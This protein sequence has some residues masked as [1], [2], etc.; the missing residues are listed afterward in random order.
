MKF[1][2][3]SLAVLGAIALAGCNSSSSDSNDNIVEPIEGLKVAFMPD[4]HFHDVYGVFE[5]GS[6]DGLPNSESGLN[7]TIRTMQSQMES[8]RLFN[9]NYF[10]MIAALDDV[11]ARGIKYVALP[12]DFSDDGQPVHM[13]GLVRI[14]DQYR[15]KHG[16]EFFAAPG[17]HDPVRPFTI[18][19]GKG[20]FLG[21]DGKQQRIYSRDGADECVGYDGDW[22][23]IDAGY[24]LPTI[25]T[26]EIQE[27]GYFE[28]MDILGHHGFFPQSNYVYFETP[29]SSEEARNNY[30]LELAQKEAAFERRQY[31]ICHEGTGGEYKKD[32]YTACSYIPD[33]TYL[34][35]P[36]EGLWLM[37][38]DANVY[39]PVAGGDDN[40]TNG[41]N[42]DGSSNAGYNKMLTHKEHVIDWIEAT[43]KAAKEQNKV[44]FSFSH[45]PM[46]D[47]Y[48]GASEEIEDIFGEGNF[49]LKRVPEDDTSKALAATGLSIHVGG[50]MHFND[51]GVKQYEIDGE[52]YTLF[53]IQAP[54]LAGYIPAYKILEIK[55]DHQ[56]EVETAV[57]KNVP[58][59]NELFEHY[60]IEQ[61]HLESIGKDDR[62][63][64]E[65][66][67]AETYYD[68]TDWHIRELTRLRFLPREWPEDVKRML[69][70]MDGDQMLILSQLQ[71]D[72]TVCQ[73][74][75]ALSEVSDVE[76]CVSGFEDQDTLEQFMLEW[77]LAKVKARDLARSSGL[78]LGHFALW[79]GEDLALDF[80]RLRN[81]DEL[82]F[83]DIDPDR[84]PQYK[85]LSEAL[86]EIDID[87]TIEEADS[88]DTTVGHAF[89]VRFGTLFYILERFAT[90]EASDHFLIDVEK[91]EI[92][93]LKTV[94]DRDS[95]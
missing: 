94:F 38:I 15:E 27:W 54:S 34:V 88:E 91:G 4:I 68:L 67:N 63:N 49:Q 50:H 60:A 13:R 93:D 45:F 8:T 40:S 92:Y 43:V 20:D 52:T 51:T 18:A 71:T 62:W 74:R 36:V 24:E 17:N 78:T 32:D 56:V 29:Y 89:K 86:S 3:L 16:L 65:I 30:S 79:N 81:A 9:E 82:A 19:A 26:E 44:L 41:K 90:G 31:E 64:R 76:P 10:A 66:L 87:I 21:V 61:E 48:N 35:E 80:Y 57:I 25:C 55:P 7:A 85:V 14:F 58:R 59:F 28:I 2:S 37:A 6:F 23:H 22:A 73:L 84:L 39:V 11:V 77:N 70:N 75:E 83:R 95:L 46:T 53:N 33:S 69:F 47:F 5:D 72:I 42:F 12:G 1:K